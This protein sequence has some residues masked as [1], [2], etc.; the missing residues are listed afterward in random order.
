MDKLI[1]TNNAVTVL[2][3]ALSDTDMTLVLDDASSFPDPESGE[4][5]RVLVRKGSNFEI[6]EISS[7]VD[8]T[9]T[10]S[11][12]GVEDTTPQSFDPGDIV[13]VTWTAE[14]IERMA[15]VGGDNTFTGDNEFTGDNT[16]TG[17]NEFTQALIVGEATEPEHAIQLGQS[18]S[19]DSVREI[20][21]QMYG[22]RV[23]SGSSDNSIITSYAASDIRKFTGHTSDVPGV[24]VDK[25]GYVYSGSFDNTVRKIDP[26]GN[27]VW[28]FT[29]HT[30]TVRGVAVD[31]G[32]YGAG[33]WD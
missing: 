12:R 28:E 14:G 13:A 33:F 7:R 23:Y 1:Y 25:D 2:A 19:E 4:A 5:F 9:L 24:A 10:V 22:P 8:N 26:N 32:L 3:E 17:D 11:D 6:I 20:L 15:A 30:S 29:G 31:P 16:F 21:V 18:V 27:E